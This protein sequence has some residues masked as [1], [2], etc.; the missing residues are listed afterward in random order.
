MEIKSYREEN[1]EDVCSFLIAL[2]RKDRGHINWNWARFEWMYGHPEFDRNAESSIGLIWDCGRV[3]GAAIYDMYFGEAFCGVLPEYETLFPEI[4]SYAYD[5]LKDGA[6]LAIAI[7]D[8][9]EREIDAAK[10]L[11]YFRTEQTETVM[12]LDLNERLSVRLPEG[13]QFAALDPIGDSEALQWLFWQGFDHGEDRAEFEREEKVVPR[14]RRHFVPELGVTAIDR[15]G[16]PVACCCLWHQEQTDYAYVE[17]VCTVPSCRGKGVARAVI[18]EAMNRARAR[19]AKT[20]YVISDMSF[21]EKLGFIR[22]YRYSFYRKNGK[23]T[24]NAD[25]R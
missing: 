21:Y 16:E 7:R 8:G 22:A 6:G 14:V 1:Y 10:K 3:V 18:F 15:S 23:Q 2:N 19:G 25:G 20:A 11:G 9:S 17:P 5:A 24:E 12:K 13:F 4:L